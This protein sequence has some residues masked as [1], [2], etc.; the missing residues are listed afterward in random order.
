[1]ILPRQRNDRLPCFGL[2]VRCVDYDQLAGGQTFG[3]DEVKNF[4]RV[5]RRCLTVLIVRD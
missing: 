3:G 4:K 2:H 1:M 5:F